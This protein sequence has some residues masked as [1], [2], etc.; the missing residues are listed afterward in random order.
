MKIFKQ[1]FV[2]SQDSANKCRKVKE[3][4]AGWQMRLRKLPTK[5]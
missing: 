2:L 4:F 5:F 3:R 1:L